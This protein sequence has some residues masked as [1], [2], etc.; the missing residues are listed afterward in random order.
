MTFLRFNNPDIYEKRIYPKPERNVSSKV[1]K[2]GRITGMSKKSSIRLRKRAARIED[3]ALWIDLTFADDV[4]E[5][6]TITE[7]AKFFT[8][9]LNA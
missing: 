5:N 2:R 3:L 1:T 7:R 6:K 8:T 9:A 4:M